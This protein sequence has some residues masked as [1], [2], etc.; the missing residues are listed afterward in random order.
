MS[1]YDVYVLRTVLLYER[2]WNFS[3]FARFQPESQEKQQG[4]ENGAPFH[5]GQA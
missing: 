3:R 5:H 4:M 1:A 2:S